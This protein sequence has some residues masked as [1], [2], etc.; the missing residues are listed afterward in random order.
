MDGLVD[1]IGLQQ[2]QR[3]RTPVEYRISLGRKEGL[4]I[5]KNRNN[6]NQSL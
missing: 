5:Y 2:T 4:K 6:K 1:G 3:S